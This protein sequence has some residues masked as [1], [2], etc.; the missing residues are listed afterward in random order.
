MQE[1]G[2]ASSWHQKTW[3]GMADGGLEGTA[4]VLLFQH[5]RGLFDSGSTST[6]RRRMIVVAFLSP[7]GSITRTYNQW[8]ESNVIP[9]YSV[10]RDGEKRNLVVGSLSPT[11]L[12][13]VVVEGGGGGL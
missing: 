11:P 6:R 2:P 9:S 12:W 4:V 1:R 8:T 5:I 7:S 10:G 13:T 3:G